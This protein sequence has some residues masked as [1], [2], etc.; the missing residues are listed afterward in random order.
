[1][2]RSKRSIVIPPANTGRAKSNK[3]AVIRTLQTKSGTNPQDIRTVRMFIT[4][5]IKLIA[6]RILLTPAICKLKIARSTP[7]DL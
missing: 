2:F 6:P 3:M 1:M 4:V 5:T 7:P